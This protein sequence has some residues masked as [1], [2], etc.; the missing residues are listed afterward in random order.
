MKSKLAEARLYG[1][2]DLGYVSANAVIQA[3]YE[4]CEGGVD[5]LQ[6]RAKKQSEAEILSM[7]REIAPICRQF[8]I[9]FIVNDFPRIACDV[10]A[11]GVHIGQDDG[12]LADVRKVVGETMIVGRSTHSLEQAR[13]AWQEGFDYLGFGPLYPTPTKLGRPGI[14]LDAIAAMER[15]IGSKIP[16]FCI[17]GI[18]FETLD[19][20]IRAGARRVVMV[21]ALLQSK[22]IRA[23]VKSVKI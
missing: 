9:P 15:E 6:L 21:S 23:A 12:S 22:D 10:D 1:I 13:A 16:V 14:G 3:T 7:A 8:G 11:D 5:I 4:L 20:V 17:G 2:V 19:Q 18:T